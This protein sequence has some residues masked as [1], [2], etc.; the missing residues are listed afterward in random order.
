MTEKSKICASCGMPMREAVDFPGRD[1]EKDHCAHCA[2]S[3]GSLKD[4]DEMLDGR[5]EVE[6]VREQSGPG[7][8]GRTAQYVLRKKG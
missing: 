8:W 3:D 6:Q 2:R 1:R 7:Y 5:F 4:F